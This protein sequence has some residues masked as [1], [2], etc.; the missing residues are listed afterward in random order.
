MVSIPKSLCFRDNLFDTKY[1]MRL[2]FLL[3]VFL[4]ATWSPLGAQ[5]PERLPFLAPAD[6]LHPGRFWTCVGLGAGAYTGVSIGLWNAWYKDFE[7]G[8]FRT[9]NDWPEWNQIDKIG[10]LTTAYHEANW[11]YRAGR[12]MGLPDRKAIWTGVA[13]GSALQLT[14]EVMDGFSEKWGFSVYDVGFNTL[15]V[16]WFAGQ[17]WAWREQRM[18]WKFSSNRP[19][20]P[21]R[22]LL[23]ADGAATSSLQERATDLYGTGTLETLLKD[24]NGQTYWLS[25]NIASFVPS[26]QERR[27]PPWLNVAV[28]YGAENMYGGFDNAWPTEDP[29]FFATEYPRYRQ[30][31][32][33]FDVDFTKI[34]THRHWLRTLFHVINFIKVP[35][36]TLEWT[37]KGKWTFY[38][39]YW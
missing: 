6:T 36:P 9:F 35:A 33:S 28:G 16:L 31:Y 2:R 12:W 29:I 23:A 7:L 24:Y 11:T 30:F 39:I 25:T 5:E 32:L 15:G 18:V 10:H 38:P 1:N 37:T 3:L 14:I 19:T 4:F 22:V 17:E 34:E 13:V 27:F 21:D 26:L 20:Y 8:P